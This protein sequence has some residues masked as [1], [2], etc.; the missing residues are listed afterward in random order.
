MPRCLVLSGDKIANKMFIGFYNGLIAPIEFDAHRKDLIRIA[1]NSI[2]NK[3]SIWAKEG[4]NEW[5][6]FGGGILLAILIIRYN[7]TAI[8]LILL[9]ISMIPIFINS[10]Q[11][12]TKYFAQ[13]TTGEV[14]IELP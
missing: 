1:R 4:N 13:V 10:D 7:K 6:L 2:L 8:P 14:T 9:L 11:E 12:T 3:I 5:Y